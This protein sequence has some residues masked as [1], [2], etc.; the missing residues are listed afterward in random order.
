[1]KKIQTKKVNRNK[2]LKNIQNA[3]SNKAWFRIHGTR[4]QYP[5]QV[6]R[7]YS[8]TLENNYPGQMLKESDPGEYM[9]QKLKLRAA[10][11]LKTRKYNSSRKPKPIPSTRQRPNESN[12]NYY[13]RVFGK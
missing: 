11:N 3:A 5:G 2:F 9:K 6:I 10:T 4:K 1:M 13:K 7:L 8:K 12:E